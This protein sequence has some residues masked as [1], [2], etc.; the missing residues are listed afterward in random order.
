M[1]P[2]KIGTEDPELRDLVER[3]GI[4]LMNILEQW[5]KQGVENVQQSNLIASSTCSCKGR[6]LK[7]KAK[8]VHTGRLD[9]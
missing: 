7:F 5:E 1:T 2:S 4:D 9:T 6:K 3:E 8:S